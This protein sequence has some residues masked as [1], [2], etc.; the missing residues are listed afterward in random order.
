[1]PSALSSNSV[2]VQHLSKPLLTTTIHVHAP[3]ASTMDS[4]PLTTSATTTLENP[5]IPPTL[6]HHQSTHSSASLPSHTLADVPS[7]PSLPLSVAPIPTLHSLSVCVPDTSFP[8]TASTLTSAPSTCEVTH[9]SVAHSQPLPH[10][11]P[12]SIHSQ[13]YPVTC[14]GVENHAHQFQFSIDIGSIHN[15]GIGE[16]LKCY[17]K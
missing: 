5:L 17:L 9:L 3:V 14:S 6:M 16:G 13:C 11:A 1:M 12:A 4:T 8:T 2:C 7:L 10:P 15:V